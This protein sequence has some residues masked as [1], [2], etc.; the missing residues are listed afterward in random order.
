MKTRQLLLC[1]LFA[2]LTAVGALMPRIPIPGTP[3]V[4]TMQTFFVFLCGLMLKP[5]YAL[6]AQLVYA[7][8]GL[9]GLPVFST[10]GGP[11]YVLS[12]SFGFVIGFAVCALIVSLFV[13]KALLALIDKRTDKQ[14]GFL[15][16]KIV[17]YS[18]MSVISMYI[19]GVAYMYL[20]L[21]F[22]LGQ[23]VTIGY[24]IVNAAGIFFFIDIIKFALAI[25]LGMAVLRRTPSIR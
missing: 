21:N 16:I 2:A 22:Y 15:I 13:R 10:G 8:I 1:A 17:L 5:R 23:T 9:L 25:P 19:C 20:I 14:R 12:P 6:T 3:L 4:I 24:V 7:A 11:G 18:L